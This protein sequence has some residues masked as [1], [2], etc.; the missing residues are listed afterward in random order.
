MHQNR[1]K[2]ERCSL[3]WGATVCDMC[4]TSV[5]FLVNLVESRQI[6]SSCSDFL[7]TKMVRCTVMLEK[8]RSVG[9][10]LVSTTSRPRW[11]SGCTPL[12]LTCCLGPHSRRFA[13]VGICLEY[14]DN[15]WWWLCQGSFPLRKRKPTIPLTSLHRKSLRCALPVPMLNYRFHS[16]LRNLRQLPLVD[17][18]VRGVREGPLT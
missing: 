13:G 1:G 6:H 15:L 5:L 8:N 11:H 16:I 9:S 7:G 3:T 18:G 12:Q 2:N 10:L 4:V 14:Y 17:S